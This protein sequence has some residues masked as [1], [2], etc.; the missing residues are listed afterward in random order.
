MRDDEV[1]VAGVG[2][3]GV[4]PPKI[5]FMEMSFSG[6]A[7][8][9]VDR[10][11]VAGVLEVSDEPLTDV[12]RAIEIVRAGDSRV[13]ARV[14]ERVDVLETYLCHASHPRL[15]SSKAREAMIYGSGRQSG[16]E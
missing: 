7:I 5:R 13:R 10:Y 2:G 3:G 11:L 8:L 1:Q 6:R 15:E 16:M 12:V 4:P 14:G 9:F